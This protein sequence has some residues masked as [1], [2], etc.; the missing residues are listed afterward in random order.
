MNNSS[1]I[2]TLISINSTKV[3]EL[4]HKCLDE[5]ITNIGFGIPSGSGGNEVYSTVEIIKV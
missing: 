5:N 2:E 3:F 4:Q 1:E